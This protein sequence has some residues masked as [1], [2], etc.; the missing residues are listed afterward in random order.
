MTLSLDDKKA[1]SDIRFAKAFEFLE[2][3]RANFKESRLK[4]SI[5]RSYYAA[6]TA[7]RALF[8]MTRRHRMI[9]C[10]WPEFGEP[11]RPP[12]ISLEELEQRIDAARSAMETQELSHLLIYGDRE[13]FANLAFLTG[14]DP[15]YEEALFI[16]DRSK[17]PLILVGNECE[18]YLGVSPLFKSGRM[19]HERFQSLSLLDQ[20]REASRPLKDILIDEGL[21]SGSRIGCVGWKYFSDA[22]HPDAEHAIELPAYMVDALREIA[23]RGNVVN[24]NRIFMNPDS[25]LRTFCSAADIAYFEWTGVLASEGVK[26]MIFGLEE[27]I[28]D[29]D[30]AKLMQYN[31]E[32]LA[33][34]MTFLSAA[35]LDR[36]LSGPVGARL[37]RRSPLALSASYRGS[38]CCRAGWIAGSEQDLAVEARDYMESFCG[39]YFEV[40]GEWYRRFGIGTTGGEL[41]TIIQEALPF[42]KFNIYLNPG[43]L[44]HLDEWLSSPIF[45]GSEITIHSGM[46]V[47]TDVIPSSPVYFSTRMEDGFAVADRDLRSTLHREFGAVYDR[48]QKRRDFMMNVLGIELSEEILPLSNIPAIVPPFFLRPHSIL[49]LE[50]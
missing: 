18:D 46:V 31:G 9:E 4:T 33:C 42:E 36:S 27:D 24:A 15:R 19:R 21:D 50:K 2:D 34:H 38:N 6:Q 12:E 3:A 32:P 43:H 29:F 14:F 30:L 41:F 28:L 26:R 20:P 17:A 22:E 39:P 37:Q 16:L 45:K 23:G 10:E 49:A 5:S 48:C 25:G 8:A 47:Q 11:V 1:L 7:V 13:H 40:M 44:I 35:N